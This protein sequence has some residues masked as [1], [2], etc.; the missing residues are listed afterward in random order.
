[1]KIWID[2]YEANVPQRLGSGQVA[3]ELLRNLEKIDKVNDYTVVLPTAP[4]P[5]LPKERENWRYRVLKPNKLWTRIALPLALFVAKQKPDIIFSPTH[6]IPRFSPK[7]VK[8]I[9]TIFDL[10]YL[11]FPEFFKK[12]DLYKLSHWTKYSIEHANHVIADSKSAKSDAIKH[13]KVSSR[14][15]TVAYPGYNADYFKKVENKEKVNQFKTKY[16]IEGDYI[17]YVSTLQP[18]KNH[19]RLI[20]A[21]QNIDN[22]K[23]VIVGKTKGA[24]RSGWMFEEILEAPKKFGVEQ[25]VIFTG[26]VPDEELLYLLNGAKAF[27][28]PSLYEG[29]GITVVDAMATGLPVIVSNNSSLPEVAGKAGLYID[30]RKVDHIEQAIRTL[31]TDPKLQSK[32]SHESLKQA[33]KFSWEKMAGQVLKVFEMVAKQGDFR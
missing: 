3:F 15:I 9:V 4:S 31:M 1:M 26:F 13:Y 11:Y 25:K 5:S 28:C 24:G 2:G 19:I 8:R 29:F 27:V 32:M 16:G 30:P 21:M 22:L 7:S 14:D 10:A 23:L 33:K 20:Q 12:S 18:R 17:I 6:Y